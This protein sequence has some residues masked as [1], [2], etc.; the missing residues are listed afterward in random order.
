MLEW[1]N[2]HMELPTELKAIEG[3]EKLYEWFGH[4][5][6]FHD[7]E[8]IALHLNRRGPSFLVV[9]TWEMTKELDAKGYYVL[10]KHVVVEF[11]L[12]DVFG[13]NL[14]GF[15]QQN[16]IF[17]LTIEKID[18][19]FR[20]LLDDCHG[21]GGTIDVAHISIRLTPGKPQNA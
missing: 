21:I 15:T 14:S 2:L 18:Q 1:S 8:V 10:E 17:G 7:A 13:L 3:S 5:P 6:N 12:K 9:H 16:V 4:W 19:G 11:V 20:V